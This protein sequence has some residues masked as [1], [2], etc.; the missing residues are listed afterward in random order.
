MQ[1]LVSNKDV[2]NYHQIDNDL[3]ILKNLTEKSELW[4]NY[5]KP[6]VTSSLLANAH[7]VSNSTSVNNNTIN[8]SLLSG[9]GSINFGRQS[10]T[11]CSSPISQ[12]SQS[13]SLSGDDLL[14]E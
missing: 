7:S 1:L 10:S 3:F 6:N 11:T 2:D 4:V 13:R 14:Q 9:I 5:G 8:M 12:L